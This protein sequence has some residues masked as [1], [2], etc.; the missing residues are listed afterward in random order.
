M[1]AA[2][3]EMVRGLRVKARRVPFPIGA[4]STGIR[5]IAGGGAGRREWLT[6][7]FAIAWARLAAALQVVEHGLS[8][9]LAAALAAA[10][11]GARRS[12]DSHCQHGKGKG[13]GDVGK[14]DED[15][16]RPV[17][18]LL[19]SRR[20]TAVSGFVV[21]VVVAPVKGRSGRPLA[22]IGEEV[23]EPV[24]TAPPLA[25]GDPPTAVA[26]GATIRFGAIAIH[27]RAPRSIGRR[28]LPGR[29][30]VPRAE[31]RCDLGAQ[32]TAGSDIAASKVG[33]G[34]VFFLSAVAADTP[35]RM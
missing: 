16:P 11:N 23:L 5:A 34:N 1:L 8:Q 12:A 26:V 15:E 6:A 32:A 20:P 3:P 2:L 7:R 9:R 21:P 10:A 31:S 24:R 35:P 14:A 29:M 27:H 4:L 28:E 22:H 25:D 18:G 17:V 33:P 30:A 13:L 19:S